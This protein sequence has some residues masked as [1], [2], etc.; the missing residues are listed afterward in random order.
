MVSGQPHTPSEVTEKNVRELGL[1][2]SGGGFRATLFHLGVIHALR[3]EDRLTEVSTICS[4]SGGSVL[5]AHLVRNWEK[6]TGTDEE[7]QGAVAELLRFIRHD[8]RGRILRR[9][10]YSAAKKFL[11]WLASKGKWSAKFEHRL[12]EFSDS[13]RPTGMLQEHYEAL[14][15]HESLNDLQ[16][17]TGS[18]PTLYILSTNLN[19]DRLCWFSHSGFCWDSDREPIAAR[20][21]LISQAVAASSAF[22]GFFPPVILRRAE[23]GVDLAVFG[24]EELYLSDGGVYDNLGI[25]QFRDSKPLRGLVEGLDGIIVSDATGGTDWTQNKRVSKLIGTAVRTID[26]FMA[27]TRDLQ[28]RLLRGEKQL[29]EKLIEV[30][31]TETV[32]DTPPP[33]LSQDLQRQLK[34]VRTDLDSFSDFEIL[35]LVSHGFSVARHRLE[36]RPERVRSSNEEPADLQDVLRIKDDS[37]LKT[38]AKLRL[39]QGSSKRRL[40]LWSRRDPASWLLLAAFLLVAVLFFS[41][42][43][44]QQRGIVI[45]YWNDEEQFTYTEWKLQIGNLSKYFKDHAEKGNLRILLDGALWSGEEH[46]KLVDPEVETLLVYSRDVDGCTTPTV[47]FQRIRGQN[48]Q[49]F[50]E[51]Y[52]AKSPTDPDAEVESLF[53]V[54]D[55]KTGRVNIPPDDLTWYEVPSNPVDV[56]S[57]VF[58]CDETPSGDWLLVSVPKYLQSGGAK[59]IVAV[60]S[61]QSVLADDVALWKLREAP[62]SNGELPL[63]FGKVAEKPQDHID[64]IRD[65]LGGWFADLRKFADEHSDRDGAF[66][67]RKILPMI[68]SDEG[69]LA[70]GSY[71]TEF[72]FTLEGL[73]EAVILTYLW[74][75]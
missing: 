27:Q 1:A 65:S 41:P 7:Y 46:P 17:A 10:P 15:K 57:V 37:R 18:R 60:A 56:L 16:D 42:E 12:Q 21:I 33:A 28:K 58:Y 23:V 71:A 24:F 59:K 5:A 44:A 20:A 72:A 9:L 11:A 52:T 49:T 45:P 35:Q 22:P 39:L 50:P 70:R 62:A 74:G 29:S 47:K 3:S 6:Y 8:V 66:L 40:G 51:V 19:Q 2:L 14:F 61:W 73:Q 36:T 69:F 30:K 68:E 67:Q 53:L 25:T 34:F 64:V 26:I 43:I 55:T 31:I 63:S 13:A 75:E 54:R 4:V 32:P 48:P 38:K